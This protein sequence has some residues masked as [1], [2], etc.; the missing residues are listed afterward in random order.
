MPAPRAYWKGYLRLSL[1]SIAVEMFPALESGSRPAMHQIH[2]P[3][4]RRIR[5]EKTVPGLGP[6]EKA[7]IARGVE[8]DD[9]TY[10]IVEPEELDA[11]RL[12]SRHTLDL[13]QFIDEAD[14]DPRYFERPY[15]L[16]PGS[17]ISTEG[18]AVMRAALREEGKIG[19]GQITM[20]GQEYLV[21]VRPCGAGLLVETLRY[22]NEVRSPED[23]F[24]DIPGD[25]EVD[26]EMT[27]LARRL[28]ADKTAPFDASAFHD[29]YADALHQLV[30]DKR[31]HRRLVHTPPES[32]RRSAEVVDL[33]EALK[34]SVAGK[35]KAASAPK[36]KRQAARSSS[37]P[38]TVKRR[39]SS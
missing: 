14:L 28:I 15:Y 38:S 6:V 34:K 17:E 2:R 22:K 9:D 36:K 26:D 37:R 5:Y 21:A 24:A 29:T 11:I 19:L 16:T 3:S 39:R 25:G 23:L 18:F 13:V 35:Q 20:R 33:M 32:G 12:E 4:G 31:A 7:D 8:V 1:V 30:E 10:V 27:K